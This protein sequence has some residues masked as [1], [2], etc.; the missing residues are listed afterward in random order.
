MF[1]WNSITYLSKNCKYFLAIFTHFPKKN[2][3]QPFQR[4]ADAMSDNIADLLTTKANDGFVCAS[5][6]LL[7]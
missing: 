1:D 2:A 3:R 7:K 5:L 6:P 4:P